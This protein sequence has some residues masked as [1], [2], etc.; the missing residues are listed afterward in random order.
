MF[1][2]ESV[3]IVGATGGNVFPAR[4]VSTLYAGGFSTCSAESSGVELKL[5][6]PVR[7]S[8]RP[9]RFCFMCLKP[10]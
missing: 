6:L 8:R 7:T 4:I 10:S 9:E 5:T 2:P 1:R 3:E